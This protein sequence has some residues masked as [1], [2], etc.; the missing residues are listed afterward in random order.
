MS[1]SLIIVENGIQRNADI[2]EFSGLKVEFGNGED[3]VVKIEKPFHFENV[4]IHINGTG[5]TVCIGK[6][7]LLRNATIWLGTKSDNRTVR[8][9]KNFLCGQ[10]T[11]DIP[12][13][14]NHVFIGDNCCFSNKIHIR[15]EDGHTLFDTN[16][17]QVINKGGYVEIGNHVYIG[18]KSY[19]GKCVILSNDTVV[20]ARSNVV[21]KFDESNVLI[22]GNPAKVVRKN[23]NFSNCSWQ[24]FNK[25]SINK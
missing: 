8:I 13:E 12:N 22:Q 2:A 24:D 7:S 9:G 14:T 21:G 16:T 4:K 15:T 1:N 10:T 3:N 18:Y 20:I 23:I 6:N 19:I 5:N 25:A 11:I 17:K